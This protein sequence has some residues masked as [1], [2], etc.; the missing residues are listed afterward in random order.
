MKRTELKTLNEKY[1]EFDG[2]TVLVCGWA[3]TVRDSKNIGFIELNDGSFKST[4]IVVE[5]EKIANYDEV[6]KQNVGASFE[7]V[8]KVIVTPNAKQP[9]EINAESVV[10]LGESATDY[11]LQKKGHTMEFLRTIPTVRA[12]GNLFN[13]VFKVRSEAAFAIHKFFNERNFVYVH[14]PIIT[15]SDCEGA[16]Q[17]FGV[18][19]FD[20]EEV[21]KAGEVDYKDDFF[22]KKAS[23]TVSGQLHEEPLTFA[24]GKTYTFGPTFRAENSNTARHA[25]EFW[26]MEPEMCYCDLQGLM[27]VEEEMVKYIIKHTLETCKDEIEF[28]NRIIDKNLIERLNGIVNSKFE[29]LPYTKAIEILEKVKD[30]FEFPVY[31]GVD[32]QS[33]HERYL[34]EVVFKKPVFLTDYPKDIKAFY[35]RQNDDGKTVAAVD[36]LVPAIGELCGGSQREERYDLLV[37]RMKEMGLNVEEYKYYTDLRRYGSVVHSGFGLGFERMVMYLTGIQNIRDVQL[38]PRTVGNLEG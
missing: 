26:M 24:F 21:A 8:G 16:G 7:I 5:R 36:L 4:Q 18:T 3:R 34:T 1:A 31:W 27:D 14:T 2:K 23:L 10:V 28:L 35:M 17:M 25:A 6:A 19:T 37:S 29:R 15:A 11:P 32:L 20:L 22:G 9:Y 30:R 12:R 38:F 33:E 13:A